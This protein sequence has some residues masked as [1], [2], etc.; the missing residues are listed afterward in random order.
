MRKRRLRQ[1]SAKATASRLV[2]TGHTIDHELLMRAVRR[3]TQCR[4]MHLYIERWLKAPVK[5]T[6]GTLLQRDRGTPQGGV[7]SPL[8]ANL[9]LHYVFDEWMRRKHPGVPFERYADDV[10]CHCHSL[11]EAQALKVDLEERMAQCH[12]QLHPICASFS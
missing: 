9:F 3:H 4:W 12:L 7:A 1:G 10:I 6:D 11:K 8:L 5:L 2:S